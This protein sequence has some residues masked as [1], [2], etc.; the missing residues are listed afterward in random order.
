M[1]YSLVEGSKPRVVFFALTVLVLVG[2]FHQPYLWWRVLTWI[3]A[4]VLLAV[5]F[6]DKLGPI[7]RGMG[8]FVEEIVFGLP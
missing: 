5:G 1:L 8:K 4:G 2:G 6:G 3:M 7:L